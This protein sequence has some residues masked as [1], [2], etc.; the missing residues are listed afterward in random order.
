[1]KSKLLLVCIPALVLALSCKHDP[2]K[3]TAAPEVNIDLPVP[4][5]AYNNADTVIMQ[6]I[7][8][9]EVELHEAFV[10]LRT[11][12]DTLFSFAPFVHELES[13]SLD[14]TWVVNGIAAPVN[15][16]FTVR[17]IN[18]ADKVTEISIPVSFAP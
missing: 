6:G 13:Y 11:N 12:T 3:V 18:H 7:L 1:M 10:M 8:T 16:F 4:M 14:T 2:D 17:A 15:S 9:D 5:T